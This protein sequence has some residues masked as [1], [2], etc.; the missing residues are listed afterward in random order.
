[1]ES[2]QHIEPPPD[3][4]VSWEQLGDERLYWTLDRV[5]WPDPMPPLVFSVAGDAL[6][7][8]LTAAGLA[9]EL[10]IAEVRVQRINT[11]RYQSAIPLTGSPPEAEAQR[12]R[13]DERI[14]AAMERLRASWTGT[15]LPEV[16]RYLA[17]WDSFDLAGVPLPALLDHLDETLARMV[18]LWEVHF[19]L[20][21]PM[22]G[23]I[24]ALG[25]LYQELFG[26]SLVTAYHLVQG[27]ENRTL[28]AGRGLWYLSRLAAARPEVRATLQL[29]EDALE[30]LGQT[31]QGRDFLSELRSYLTEFGQR[32]DSLY[33]DRPS[34]ADDPTPVLEQIRGLVQREDRDVVGELVASWDERDELVRQTRSRL[35]GYP[36]PVR[37]EFE[38]LLAAAQGA[39][40]LTEDHN[41]WIDSHAIQRVRRVFLEC[42]Q[43][44]AA[45]SVLAAPD[46]VFF[47]TAAELRISLAGPNGMDQRT[48][49]AERRAEMARFRVVNP[50]AELGT[51]PVKD[52]PLANRLGSDSLV[53]RGHAASSGRVQ[54]VARVLRSLDEAG[55]LAP[56][57]VLVTVSLSSS[58]TPLFAT[59]A[60]VVTDAGGILSHA[61]VVAREYRLPAVLGADGATSY[62][63][64]GD[65]VEV[66]GDRGLVR[67]LAGRTG[68]VARQ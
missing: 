67:L 56:D 42:G 68:A 35:T 49:V 2:G 55:R 29:G 63:H 61:A 12:L 65:L 51:R 5:H 7:R 60:A 45:Q 14:R 24:R 8:G 4:P 33:F 21:S 47:L 18:R 54:G 52:S 64:D 38:F 20:A 27:I 32:G 16:Q 6:A 37:D 36:A 40:A 17:A 62:I 57:E 13:S 59:A 19:L 43:R 28:L 9:Y 1:V 34:W 30:T 10:P 46:D 41:F 39:V 48:I 22:H 50:P 11:Y 26:E 15:W 58:W 25:R 53:L 66:D 31:A 3:F 44:L 23:A